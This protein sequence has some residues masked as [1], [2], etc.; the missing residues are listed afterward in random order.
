MMLCAPT[1]VCATLSQEL[2][3]AL[4]DSQGKRVSEVNAQI[5]ATT[6]ADV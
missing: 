5:T 6:M 2:V 1:W 4:K 3:N